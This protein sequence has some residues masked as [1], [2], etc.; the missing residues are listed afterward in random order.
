MQIF[1]LRYINPICHAFTACTDEITA[2]GRAGAGRGMTF[3]DM[4]ENGGWT[5]PRLRVQQATGLR[6][7]ASNNELEQRECPALPPTDRRLVF[8]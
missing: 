6:T 7:K 1:P 3:C 5:N 2:H 8:V 4:R